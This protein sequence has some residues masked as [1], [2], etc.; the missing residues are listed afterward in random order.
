MSAITFGLGIAFEHELDFSTP[1]I[2]CDEIIRVATTVFANI[3]RALCFC[4]L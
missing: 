3:V 1:G 4:H 2:L